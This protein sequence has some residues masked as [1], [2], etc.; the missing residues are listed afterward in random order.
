MFRLNGGA[1]V[2]LENVLSTTKL[3]LA[4]HLSNEIKSKDQILD[5]YLAH[6]TVV[7]DFVP[8]DKTNTGIKIA[9][10]SI[11]SFVQAIFK[12][13]F[14]ADFV[15]HF[16]VKALDSNGHEIMYSITGKE[17][18]HQMGNGDA[19]YWLKHTFF[20]ENTPESRMIEAKSKISQIENGLRGVIVQILFQNK[21][22]NWWELCVDE[23]V[24]ESASGVYSQNN[25]GISTSD[26]KELI[27]STNLIHLDN[28]I[29]KNWPHFSNLFDGLSKT[30]FSSAM[31]SLNN[32]RKDE[33]HNREI[34]NEAIGKL[35]V[36][37]DLFMKAIAK[38]FPDVVP[39]YLVDIWK[40]SLSDIVN[41]RDHPILHETDSLTTKVEK[42]KR[43]SNTFSNMETRLKAVNAPIGYHELHERF[44]NIISSHKVEFHNFALYAE[45]GLD[46]KVLETSL[47]LSE[48]D[49]QLNNFHRDYLMELS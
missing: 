36:Y 8:A 28:I 44:V 10:N 49:N 16:A 32:I 43:I 41:D 21:G 4:S 34:T 20:Q 5:V 26:S 47:K 9:M 33:S 46:D 12:D 30:K 48:L 18:A 17:H 2:T 25:K 1:I 27:A 13:E 29:A 40:K 39:K 19:I 15:Q 45:Q 23:K 37:F 24:K 22:D 11:M 38:K 3:G 14:D 42:L 31:S 35:R 6:T 7:C